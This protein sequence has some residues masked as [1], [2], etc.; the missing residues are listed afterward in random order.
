MRHI[1]ATGYKVIA[2][3]INQIKQSTSPQFTDSQLVCI[4][5]IFTGNLIDDNPKFKEN[6]FMEDCGL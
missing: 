5:Y 1:T 3:S 4:Y 6:K 2:K